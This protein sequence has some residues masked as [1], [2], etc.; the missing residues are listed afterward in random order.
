MR[1]R[2]LQYDDVLNRQR[3][4]IYGLRNQALRDEHPRPLLFTFVSDEIAVRL[5][6]FFPDE[7]ARPED[8]ELESFC[9]W[10]RTTFPLR[11]DV[12]EIRGLDR[13]AAQKVALSKIENFYKERDEFESPDALA[14]MERYIIIRGIDKNWQ[15]HLTEME[16]LRRSVGLRGY[17]QKDPLNEYKNEAYNYFE[18]MLGR[19]RGDI[20]NGLFRTA[21]SMDA[22]QQLI[23]RIQ[24]LVVTTGP[25]DSPVS[26]A[27]EAKEEK[28]ATAEPRKTPG[29]TIRR[30]Y[31]RIGR[32]DAVRVRKGPET[33]ILKWKKAEALIREQGWELEEILEGESATQK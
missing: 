10:Y 24:R 4:I 15:D 5:E 25:E 27:E 21:T 17:A 28:S 31:P 12:E 2:L 33:Q 18:N 13:D 7:H 30:E 22:F 23:Q 11:L 16:E 20:C 26:L 9:S 8:I 32:N 6:P 29:I 19:I 3:E 14:N 1:K